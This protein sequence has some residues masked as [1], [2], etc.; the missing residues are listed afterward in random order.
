MKEIRLTPVQIC[1]AL[2]IARDTFG[3]F[4]FTYVPNAIKE[5]EDVTSGPDADFWE[6]SACC[7]CFFPK[8]AWEESAS[9]IGMALDDEDFETRKRGF[10]QVCFILG[11]SAEDDVVAIHPSF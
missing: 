10:E 11:C 6:N 2:K 3:T 1:R 7:A 5:G 9:D 4:E 8:L